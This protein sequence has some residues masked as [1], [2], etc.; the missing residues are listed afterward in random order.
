MNLPLVLAA[1]GYGAA[2]G[3]LLPGPV[4]RLAV[5]PGEPWRTACPEGHRLPV[6]RARCPRCG[7]R[8][9]PDARLTAAV[10]A[11]VCGLLALAAGPRPET[12]VWL[13]L[14]PSAVLLAAVD[15]AVRRLPD[16]LTLPMAGAG[17]ALL[18]GASLLPGAAGA[19][20]GALLGALALG[21]FLFALFLVSPA[22]MGFGDVK[23][24]LT[25]GLV[26]GWYGWW[27][28]L[29]GAFAGFL[30]GALTGLALI[31]AGRAGRRSA[32]PFGPFLLL[33]ALAGMLVP[34]AV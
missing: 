2:A 32:L 23:L 15:L 21:G 27:P 25:V 14:A 30:L 20:T 6:P 10:T 12:A 19:W 31:A 7:A 4:H 8:G 17:A 33:G 11:A 13:L 16:A 9:G 22:G 3:A 24:G 34:G 18:G 5:P 29:A 26:L 28:L 1:A